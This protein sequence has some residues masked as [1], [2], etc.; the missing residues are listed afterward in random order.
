MLNE[1]MTLSML[2]DQH[3]SGIYYK[4]DIEIVF[5]EGARLW[6]ADNNSYIDC[7]GG[8]GAANL[9]HGNPV[10]REAIRQ[11][12]DQLISCPELFHNPVRAQFQ[13][14][15]CEAAGMPRVFLCSSGTEAI[16]GAIKFARL[17]TGRSGIIAAMRGFHGRTLGS[18]SATWNS[19]YRDPFLPLVPEF[20]HVPFNNIEKL[21]AALTPNTAAVLLEPVQGEG[22]VHPADPAYLAEVQRLCNENGTLL[23]LDEIQTGFGRTG[24]LFAFQGYGIQPDLVCL[25]KSIAGGIPMGAVLIGERIGVLPAGSHGTTFGGNPLACAA[26][27]AVLKVLQGTSLIQRT[28]QRGDL[29]LE[30]LR[31]A[32]PE[33]TVREVRGRGLMIGIELRGKVAPVLKALQS[34]GV[35]ALPAGQTVLRLLPPLVITDDELQQAVDVITEVLTDAV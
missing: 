35:L 26:G 18:L 15:L 6:D 27:L 34:R 14:T 1:S 2:E 23:I 20:S 3:T 9:G 31:A 12:A 24:D 19:T 5:G 29:L 21:A 25:A 32:L 28:R 8:Q 4:R 30:Q 13:A 16:E 11:Q 10:I 7:V 33:S 17:S 22:G